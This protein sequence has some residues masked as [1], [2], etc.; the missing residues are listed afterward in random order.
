MSQP[1]IL[2]VE[3][4]TDSQSVLCW[5]VES[6]GAT[7][8]LAGSVAEA[9]QQITATEGMV[10]GLVLDFHLPDGDGMQLGLQLKRQIDRPG[11]PLIGVTAYY[12]PELRNQALAAGYDACFA[13]PLPMDEFIAT[14]N[15]LVK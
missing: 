5:A 14:L 3:D 4:D 2:V 6:R 1:T 15:R 9:N 13:K 11:V 10:N 7:C 8:L 12:T